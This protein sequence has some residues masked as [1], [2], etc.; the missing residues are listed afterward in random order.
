MAARMQSDH[1]FSVALQLSRWIYSL[2]M[3][4]SM[5]SHFPS[6]RPAPTPQ[7]FR[8]FA[9]WAV[10]IPQPV[11]GSPMHA[12]RHAISSMVGIVLPTSLQFLSIQR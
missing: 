6:H 7:G 4:P 12:D 9:A 11:L 1:I 10:L 2:K 5:I 8:T 3:P